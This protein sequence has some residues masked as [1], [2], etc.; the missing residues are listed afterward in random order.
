MESKS[1]LVWSDCTVVLDSP[2][3][4]HLKLVV[5]IFPFD[6]ELDDSLRLYNPVENLVLKIK[7]I[8]INYINNR[9]DDLS[10]G[11]N[12]LRLRRI[13]SLKFSHELV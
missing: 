9:S 4:V 8:G 5:V 6:S 2:T 13:L 10:G 1:T 7:W 12:E 11:L 3:A